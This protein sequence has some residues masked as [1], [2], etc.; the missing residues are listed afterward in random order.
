MNTPTLRIEYLT[1]EEYPTPRFRAVVY[2][3]PEQTVKIRAKVI[4][5]AESE[6]LKDCV[7]AAKKAYPEL[8]LVDYDWNVLSYG[9]TNIVNVIS[10]NYTFSL[11]LVH[12]VL[13]RRCTL[14][15]R[16]K[17]FPCTVFKDLE[18]H[19]TIGVEFTFNGVVE[20]NFFCRPGTGVMTSIYASWRLLEL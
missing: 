4:W 11:P 18:E 9:K 12:M 1:G 3:R 19:N 17:L 13:E 6:D 7:N 10:R 15:D 20:R 8:I 2:D 14:T 5:I 16:I